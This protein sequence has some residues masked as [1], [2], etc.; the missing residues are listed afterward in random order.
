V[1]VLACA[2]LAAVGLVAGCV[3]T[4]A[5]GGSLAT[6]PALMLVGLPADVANATNRVAV[7]SQSLAAVG[8]FARVGVFDRRGLL[9]VI[10]TSAVGALGGALVATAVPVEVL[11]IV[12]CSVMIGMAGLLALRPAAVVAEPSAAAPW[13]QRRGLGLLALLATGFYGGL[14]QAGVGFLLVAALSG[15][16]GYGIGPA[17]A[18]KSLATLVFSA[19]ALAI[20]IGHGLVAWVPA[21]VLAVFTAIGSLVGVRLALRTAPRA[22][23]WL[24]FVGVVATSIA[25]IAH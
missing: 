11:E 21:L 16:V 3:N 20:F 23:R 10:A 14:V 24:L 22:M 8:G 6:I 4:I 1:D 7:A 9:P 2:A 25:A 18:L 19:V 15:V 17:N 13:S 12:L 5:G